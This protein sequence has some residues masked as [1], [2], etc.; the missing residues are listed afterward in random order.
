MFTPKSRWRAAAA[1]NKETMER[2]Q[3]GQLSCISS[4]V[5]QPS[6][7]AAVSRPN[8]RPKTRLASS[9]PA[10]NINPK[11]FGKPLFWFLPKSSKKLDKFSEKNKNK[12]SFISKKDSRQNLLLPSLSFRLSS[13]SSFSF[14][15]SDDD[16]GSDATEMSI[17]TDDH[18]TDESSL[19]DDDDESSSLRG[20][21]FLP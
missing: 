20:I 16:D 13:R 1:T 5:E 3:S 4:L 18:S 17:E 19:A 21:S 9:L 10:T 2:K 15:L 12:N 6:A 8:S 11:S 7:A 14:R